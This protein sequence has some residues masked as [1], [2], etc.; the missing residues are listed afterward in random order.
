MKNDDI[1]IS[2]KHLPLR[3][4]LFVLAFAIAIAAFTYGVKKWTG[5]EAGYTAVLARAD[6]DAPMYAVN[7][8]LTYNFDG[9]SRSIRVMKNEL[10]DAYSDALGRLY[11][12][13]DPEHA[14]PGFSG[15][16]A[17]LNHHLN[18][19]YTVPR[20]LFDILCDALERTERGSGFSIYAAPLY[21]EWQS[22]AYS[23][24]AADFDPLRNAD[25]AERLRA[26][27]EQCADPDNCSLEI[28]DAEKCVVR[29]NAAQS[30]LDFLTAYELPRTVLDLGCL[31][32]AYILRGVA[33]ALEQRG[34]VDGY[35]STTGGLTKSLSGHLDG[36]YV[37]YSY[38]NET[39]T[40]C[41]ALPVAPGTACAM[42]HAFPI[43]EGEAG[44]YS[45]DGTLRCAVRPAL[46][47]T[48]EMLS[49]VFVMQKDGDIVNASHTAL[50]R[51]FGDAEG[52]DASSA[53]L[54]LWTESD[55]RTLYAEGPACALVTP[56]PD[57]V[58]AEST[59][60]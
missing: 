15:N 56:E 21:A 28:V 27:A 19:E 47:G 49:S 45:V 12:L 22:I 8:R 55:G 34:F 59:S 4:V 35:L 58:L 13:L 44:F 32:D 36:E 20:E 30:Y 5:N 38:V 43:T 11:K 23:A 10:S 33:E 3:I 18:R 31:K 39:P 48:D 14:Y 17:D 2:T 41:A 57:F 51:F 53:D 26:I 52:T 25:E 50:R 54:M 9:G 7:I 29:L 46:P 60:P 40:L 37:I 16:L 42:F 6:G 1:D 24:D